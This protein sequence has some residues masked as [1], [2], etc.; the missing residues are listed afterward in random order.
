LYSDPERP[1]SSYLCDKNAKKFR[2][3]VEFLRG[4][5]YWAWTDEKTA[6]N[7]DTTSLFSRRNLLTAASGAGSLEYVMMAID[8][9]GFPPSRFPY[10]VNA[11]IQNGRLE[12]VSLLHRLG[13]EKTLDVQ[14]RTASELAH[15]IIYAARMAERAI[16]HH[17]LLQGAAL[18]P[19]EEADYLWRSLWQGMDRGLLG[20][21]W[22]FQEI[23]GILWH[24]LLHTEE[25]G[26]TNPYLPRRHISS[27][28]FGEL[29]H[30]NVARL[31]SST[32]DSF[33]FYSPR[34]DT[35]STEPFRFWSLSLTKQM[36]ECLDNPEQPLAP[37]I[38]WSTGGIISKYVKAIDGN[39]KATAGLAE[40][41]E[42]T[43]LA[44]SFAQRLILPLETMRTDLKRDRW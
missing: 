2:A 17:L 23:E 8:V 36:N 39:T 13:G 27:L 7:H 33:L 22:I 21:E 38:T 9:L 44:G 24:V 15:P 5:D 4:E 42:G 25:V 18:L 12:V 31:W 11:A 41:A 1:A 30:G 3:G 19:H 35:W 32:N 20:Y 10:A 34:F 29:M 40:E 6:N 14:M 37:W 28:P 43:R 26:T 16:I